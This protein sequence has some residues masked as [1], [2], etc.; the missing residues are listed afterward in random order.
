MDMNVNNTD[1]TEPETPSELYASRVKI[2]PKDVSGLFRRLKWAALIIL[3]GIY[4]GLPWVR[5]DRGPGVPDQAILADMAGRRLFFFEIEIW[6][7]EIYYLTGLLIIGAI[8]LFLVTALAGRIWC[9]FACPQTVWTDLYMLVERWIEGGRNQRIKLDAAPFSL[10]KLWKRTAKHS[11]WML[12]AMATGGAWILYFVDAPTITVDIFTGQAST[13]V[14]GFI[15]LFT[16]TTYVLAGLAREQVCTYMC[17]W[18]RFQG[19][20]FDEDSLIV[21]YEEW[22][23]EPR[24][25]AKG[26]QK[27][28][29]GDCVDCDLCVNVCPT[30]IDIRNGQQMQCIGCAL[31]VD[32][33]NSVMS[34]LGREPNLIAYDSI[35]N[36]NARAQGRPATRNFFRLRTIIYSLILLL[37]ISLMVYGLASRA[38][39]EINLQRD[40]A[41]LFITLSDGE[42]RNG[43]TLKILNME[44]RNRVFRLRTADMDK[45]MISVIGY[46]KNGAISVDLPVKSDSV[47]T[48]RVFVRVPVG[49]LKAQ[50]TE[51]E[52]VLK[53]LE[54]GA[55]S[56]Q[57]TFFFGPKK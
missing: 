6:P 50:S 14:Y 13:T 36:M 21:T 41:P 37:I 27:D 38:N 17:P 45:A 52:F 54:T 19:A 11:A 34:K 15:A 18:P 24:G 25:K 46:E 47:G 20:M 28:K 4:Y 1:A 10:N 53:D 30:G 33:C 40:R 29:L 26:K 5:W 55:Q 49:T 31:C 44:R 48:F 9:G 22:R 2:H 32:A 43:Y 7:Q 35:A 57:H 8:G 12:I 56:D 3:L 39:V 51:M 16:G 42:I 23:G